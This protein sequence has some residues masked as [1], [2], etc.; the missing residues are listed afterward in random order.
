MA[1]I[2]ILK[3]G[4]QMFQHSFF[5]TA[6]CYLQLYITI[7][8][9]DIFAN[10]VRFKLSIAWRNINILKNIHNTLKNCTDFQNRKILSM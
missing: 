1:K 5:L 9:K 10:S 6:V 4:L 7:Y 8:S 3:V 2:Q